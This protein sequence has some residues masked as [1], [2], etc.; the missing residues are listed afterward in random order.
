MTRRRKLE[1]IDNHVEAIKKVVKEN[2]IKLPGI[3]NIFINRISETIH[4]TKQK[5]MENP[6]NIH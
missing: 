4:P 2:N 3:I 1:I 6:F 5:D